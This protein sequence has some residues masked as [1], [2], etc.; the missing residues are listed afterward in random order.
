MAITSPAIDQVFAAAK[1][2]QSIT[3]T[4]DAK[5][6][7]GATIA[8]VEFFHGDTKIGEATAAPYTVTWE[9]VKDGSY[10]LTARAT[11]ST[12]SATTSS[13][14][15][16]HVNRTRTH[17]GWQVRDIG[18]VPIPGNT[19]LKDGVFTMKGSGK[20]AGWNDSFHFAY[21]AVGFSRR[22]EVLEITARLD[23][24]SRNHIGAVA[25]VMVR[26]D[27]EPDSPFML[28]GIGYSASS[29]DGSGRRAMAIRVASH[30][31][32]PSVGEWPDGL[33]EKPYWLRLVARS[34]PTGNDT[35]FEAF[36]S[37]N[38]LN[39]DRI[40]Y[41]RIAMRTSRFYVGLVVDGN[42]EANGVHN[43]ITATFSQVKVNR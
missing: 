5:A 35:E 9:G 43:Y 41:E 8:K 19:A 38:S 16:I 42:Q 2:K 22:G 29:E 15:P 32:R 36:L 30:G 7:D 33:G 11:D 25:G 23:G 3:I 14:V 28:A 4:A 26:Q 21:K 13:L 20:I 31:T 12:G 24:I 1:N 34:L 40:G 6:L 17:S 27:L 10:C 39:W 18:E 37:D